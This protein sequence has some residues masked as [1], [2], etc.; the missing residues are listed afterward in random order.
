METGTI[1]QEVEVAASVEPK[2][3][4]S[5]KPEPE[6][7]GA[8]EVEVAAS[9]EPEGG[10]AA[11]VEPEGG[12]AAAST[13]QE[14]K[15][16]PDGKAFVLPVQRDTFVSNKVLN[17]PLLPQMKC[18]HLE[19]KYE[20]MEGNDCG[21]LIPP[22]IKKRY[23]L[24]FDKHDLKS[25]NIFLLNLIN[26]IKNQIFLDMQAINSK[27]KIET[28][29][30][31]DSSEVAFD[32]MLNNE[33]L[34]NVLGMLD[35]N[36][37]KVH[38]GTI[39]AYPSTIR[40]ISGAGSFFRKSILSDEHF[41]HVCIY[42]GYGLVCEI[43]GI[44]DAHI[45]GK[46]SPTLCI[47][48]LNDFI[49]SA[50]RKALGTQ[51]KS[52]IIEYEKRR[53]TNGTLP[54]EPYAEN[55]K[56]TKKYT[57]KKDKELFKDG[58]ATKRLKAQDPYIQTFGLTERLPYNY[59]EEQKSVKKKRKGTLS[60]IKNDED[61]GMKKCWPNSKE[62]RP[63]TIK[64]WIQMLNRV[65]IY[66]THI[67]C[68][69]QKEEFKY[70]D[71]EYIIKEKNIEV[72]SSVPN[73]L[74]T[75]VLTRTHR[76]IKKKGYLPFFRDCQSATMWIKNSYTSIPF[77]NI[78]T[79]TPGFENASGILMTERI[80]SASKMTASKMTASK[81]GKKDKSL[82]TRANY[83]TFQIPTDWKVPLDKDGII[84]PPHLVQP[85][86]YLKH[87]T[88][89]NIKTELEKVYLDGI[90]KEQLESEYT[91][92]VPFNDTDDWF[93]RERHEDISSIDSVLNKIAVERMRKSSQKMM[94]KFVAKGKISIMP[95]TTS[96]AGLNTIKRTKKHKKNTPKK[97]KV[98]RNKKKKKVISVKKKNIKFKRSK[99]RSK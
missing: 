59:P 25:H 81:M 9:V 44:S 92:H 76:S 13:E 1:T 66:S 98:K 28:P 85:P 62:D 54:C 30:P 65:I 6:G 53:A 27:L 14:V 26:K 40:N 33:E 56:Y 48:T 50:Q 23:L 72:K 73:S 12:G 93:N 5:T 83:T 43:A 21:Y 49:A 99:Y 79:E 61:N 2:V 75:I 71:P 45:T 24:L 78:S 8:A 16:S 77:D 42:I 84:L 94:K 58:E 60:W 37:W 68:A 4:A 86:P 87:F 70:K 15:Y 90:D 57:K 38:I 67:S 34:M 96:T 64:H 31:N 55:K 35:E 91:K 32:T 51:D 41:Q 95:S 10:G 22:D 97:S 82:R 52:L 3:V 20:E 47:T 46:K 74:T 7:G 36:Q 17:V 39:L 18:P 69:T 11:S 88:E 19:G 63:P 80:M 29:I 89:E